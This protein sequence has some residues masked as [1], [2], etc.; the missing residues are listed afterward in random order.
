MIQF[1]SGKLAYVNDPRNLKFKDYLDTSVLPALPKG[2]IGNLTV[3]NQISASPGWGMLMNDSL[4]DCAIAGP[5]HETMLLTDEGVALAKFKDANAQ[6]D[7]S[8]VSG[9]NPKDPSSDVGCQISDVLSYRQKKGLIDA[10]GVRHQI[11]AYV[12]LDQTVQNEILMGIYLFGCVGIGIEFPDSAMTQFNNGQ[13]WDVVKGA[14]IEGGHYVPVVYF[15][16]TYFYCITWGAVQKMTIAFFKKYCDEAWIALSQDFMKNGVSPL[17]FNLAA[18]QADVTAITGTPIPD[19]VDPTPVPPSPVPP[20]PTPVN[21]PVTPPTDTQR[22]EAIEKLINTKYI[23]Q[24]KFI[25]GVK[26]AMTGYSG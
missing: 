14:T 13:V 11:G 26:T 22:L 23:T 16:G 4:G 17:G 15:D 6:A 1:K 5:E 21:P 9:Y 2:P 3:V 25:A 19:P 12:Q 7:Y 20:Q 18:L 24:K 8:A 10:A